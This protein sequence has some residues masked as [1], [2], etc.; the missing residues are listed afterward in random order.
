MPQ[1]PTS[2]SP[3][4]RATDWDESAN[5]GR[6]GYADYSG[7]P[8]IPIEHDTLKAGDK[9]P[10][11]EHGGNSGR[12]YALSPGKLVRLVGQPIVSGTRYAIEQLRC[13]LCGEQFKATVPASVLSAPKYA[14]SVGTNIAMARYT[15]GVP[16]KRLESWQGYHGIPLPDAS[17]WDIIMR[18]YACVQPVYE[19]MQRLSTQAE[20]Y[21]YD[22]TSQKILSTINN[23]QG[24]VCTTAVAS[25]L[26]EHWL[27][28]F[29]TSQQTAASN[30]TPILSAR[31]DS[32]PFF[33][34]TDA[35]RTNLPYKVSEDLQARWILC[36]CLVH[37]RRKFFELQGY[38]D[39]GID[40][41]LEQIGL[42]YQHEKHCRQHNLDAEQRLYYHQTHSAPALQA[43][44]TWLN[45]QLLYELTEANSALGQAM[46]YLLRH[47]QPLTRFLHHPGVPIDNSLAERLIKVAIRHRRN[48]LFYRT[49]KG[50]QVGDVLMSILH[51]AARAEVNVFDYLNQ[52]QYHCDAVAAEPE[53]WL[54]WHYQDTLMQH[55]APTKMQAA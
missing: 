30:I 26:G 33:T 5:H 11:C 28:L 22:D 16:F 18:V 3:S 54:P 25:Q 46:R 36:F 51:T 21:Y 15:M 10:S 34:M 35:S 50:A 17:Q 43:L 42:V 4:Q 13:G 32:A 41:V 52:L 20:G 27:H 45:N 1:Q 40:F 29:Y 48:S 7:C 37:G 31:E 38:D 9:C 2:P 49:P 8:E 24:K 6:L 39:R 23:G 19:C 47:W 14:P 53:A 55:T 44:H 12:L